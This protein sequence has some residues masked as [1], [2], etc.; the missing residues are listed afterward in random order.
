MLL[1]SIYFIY[2]IYSNS[3]DTFYTSIY[4]LSISIIYFLCVGACPHV[5]WYT[6]CVPTEV[7][8]AWG[9]W[10]WSCSKLWESSSVN[11]IFVLASPCKRHRSTALYLLA[12]SLDWAGSVLFS[13]GSNPWP[14]PPSVWISP[15]LLWLHPPVLR[16]HS[17]PRA[18][19][20]PASSPLSPSALSFCPVGSLKTPHLILGSC[21]SLPSHR[22]FTVTLNGE[23]GQS[24]YVSMHWSG[25]QPD[26]GF[27]I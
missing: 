2:S 16:M 20:P 8:R 6:M 4:I 12:A 23:Q 26:L 17:R 1:F 27:R 19:G 11:E 3:I 5:C 21:I 22:P 15:G 18:P 10:H 24:V 14:L 9:P 7:R 25:W 13:S